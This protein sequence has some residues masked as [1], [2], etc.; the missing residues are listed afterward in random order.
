MKGP[1]TVRMI[2]M[3][4][5]PDTSEAGWM[6]ASIAAYMT[7]SKTSKPS[8]TSMP[9]TSPCQGRFHHVRPICSSSQTP[10]PFASSSVYAPP[11]DMEISGTPKS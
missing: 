8:P 1:K 6:T 9:T 2:Q 10:R 7:F 4:S 5:T 3:S 11:R